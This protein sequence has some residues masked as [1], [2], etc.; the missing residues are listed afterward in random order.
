MG[1]AGLILDGLPDDLVGR[2]EQAPAQ[3]PPADPVS[4]ELLMRRYQAGDGRAFETLYRRHRAPLHRFV[5]RMIGSEEADEVFQDVWLGVIKGRAGY[6][7]TARFATY[8]FTIAHHRAAE[9]LR[10][11]GRAALV[12]LGEDEE[13]NLPDGEPGP[14]NVTL[15]TELGRALADAI[16]SL[17]A[18]QREAFLM[19]AEGGLRL[20][21]IAQAC[22]VPR[23]T[24]KSRLR[25]ASRRLRLALESWK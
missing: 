23:E 13:E 7:P 3:E 8:L 25:Y 22:G 19:Q 10:R 1:A 18:A 24:V 15:N 9:K 12:T 17:P 2:C 14:L 21:E 20:E 16:A 6:N 4:D 5:Q 11:R